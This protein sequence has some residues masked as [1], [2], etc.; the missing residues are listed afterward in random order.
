MN[1]PTFFS[2]ALAAVVLAAL[3]ACA[4]E[5]PAVPEAPAP[6]VFAPGECDA[7][8]AQF[9]VGKAWDV[10]LAEQARTRARA[11]RLRTV[12]PGEFVT[13]EFDARRLTLQLDGQGR[14]I[15]AR[16]G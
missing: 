14:V 15:A 9:A 6:P 10:A 4:E 1:H 11:E 12:R 8:S 5:P 7:Q 16:C 3:A 2:R 13:M